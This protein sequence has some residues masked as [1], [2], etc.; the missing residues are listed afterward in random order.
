MKKTL[1]V[2]LLIIS[3]LIISGCGTGEVVKDIEDTL[4]EETPEPIEEVKE[5]LQDNSRHITIYADRYTDGK[6]SYGIGV[7]N[8]AGECNWIGGVLTLEVKDAEGN[9]LKTHT[10]TITEKTDIICEQKELYI[11]I[12]MG[13]QIYDAVSMDAQYKAFDGQT[14]YEEGVDITEMLEWY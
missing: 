6:I 3:I 13:D 2:G 7:Y 10:Y 1:I 5:E 4:E 9:I 14:Y 12:N 11:D 8:D